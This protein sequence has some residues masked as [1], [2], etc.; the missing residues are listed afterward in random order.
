[1][2][3]AISSSDDLV[4]VCTPYEWLG[5]ELIVLGNEA[6]D[7]GFEIIERPEDAVPETSPCQFCEEALN[8]VQPRA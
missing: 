5:L 3:P 7:R 2:E 4:W 8:R 1:L 6:V